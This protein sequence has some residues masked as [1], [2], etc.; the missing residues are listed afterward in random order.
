M[1]KLD[2]FIID[3]GKVLPD[4]TE[5][6]LTE[7]FYLLELFNSQYTEED[8]NKARYLHKRLVTYLISHDEIPTD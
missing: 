7:I 1:S 2:R 5:D 6:D 8:G 4:R 3:A